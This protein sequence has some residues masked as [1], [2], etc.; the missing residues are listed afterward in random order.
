MGLWRKHFNWLHNCNRHHTI[1]ILLRAPPTNTHQPYQWC[2]IS[3]LLNLYYQCS[4]LCKSTSPLKTINSRPTSTQLAGRTSRMPEH[5]KGRKCV[6]H[7]ILLGFFLFYWLSKKRIFLSLCSVVLV[8]PFIM[9]IVWCRA[10]CSWRDEG[11]WEFYY[12][13]CG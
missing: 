2:A 9:F 6:K 11:S 13:G 3:S 5:Q 7:S 4:K 10:C 8:R 12:R 1:S